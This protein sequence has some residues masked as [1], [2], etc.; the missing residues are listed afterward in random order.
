MEDE[1]VGGFSSDNDGGV[2][3]APNFPTYT[4]QFNK[5]F[6]YYLAIGMTYE[7]FWEQDCE[8]VIYYR[9]A[10]EIKQSLQ[11]Q[12]AWLQGAYF[13]EAILD[14]SPILHDYVKKGTKPIPYRNEPYEFGLDKE[15]KQLQ[16]AEKDARAK[17]YMEAFA[18]SMNKK[19]SQK[20]DSNNGR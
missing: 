7:Q 20:G 1:L 8:L 16:D 11:N 4:A 9:K 2:N 10:A 6:P 15:A 14:A 12:Q 5:V 18:A 19:F 3:I 13:Y 17:A